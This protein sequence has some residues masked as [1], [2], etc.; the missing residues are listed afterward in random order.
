MR[1]FLSFFIHFIFLKE[2]IFIVLIAILTK[3]RLPSCK[4][5]LFIRARGLI[6]TKFWIMRRRD[7]KV[8][9]IK[10]RLTKHHPRQVTNFIKNKELYKEVAKIYT[11]KLSCLIFYFNFNCITCFNLKQRNL[12]DQI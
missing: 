9:A 5:L 2:I 4:Y 11:N 8:K 10:S 12:F 6:S 7:L 1:I 3:I